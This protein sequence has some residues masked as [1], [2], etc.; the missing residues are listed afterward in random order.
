MNQCLTYISG[1]GCPTLGYIGP[2][3]GIAIAGSFLAILTATMST[4]SV[5]L[6]WPVKLMWKIATG[7]RPPKNAAYKRVI[8][9]GFD[10][11][12]PTTVEPMMQRG[13]LPTFSK[14]A[15]SGC[16]RRLGTTWPALSPVAW[17][18]FATGSN[19]GKH[20]IYDFVSR[21]QGTYRP[22]MSSVRIEPSHRALKLGKLRWPLGRSRVEQLRRSKPFWHA[23]GEAGYF[24]AILRVPITFPPDKFNGVQLS[25]MCVPDLRG[26]QG[27]YLRYTES[28]DSEPAD[29]SGDVIAVSRSANV[30]RSYLP[31]IQDPYR[32][33]GRTT[34][35]PFE[36]K[37]TKTNELLL[38]ID[39]QKVPLQL[40]TY[41]PWVRIRFR[42]TNGQ[43]VTGICRFRITRF[44]PPFQ[45]YVT[46]IQIDPAAPVMQIS[47]P[48]VF[49]K[50]LFKRQG[51]FA[52]LGLAEDTSALSDGAIDED[53]FLEQAYAIHQER[54][55]MLFDSMERVNQGA[56]TCV[57][58]APDRVQH[59]FYR[60]EDQ[61]H[62]ANADNDQTHR[63]VIRDM[64]I[65][66]DQTLKEI[67]DR[68]DERTAVIVMSDHGFASFRR[69]VDLN[70]WLRDHGYLKLRDDKQHSDEPDLKDVDWSQTTAYAFGL[71]GI[72][73]NL[74]GREPHGIVDRGE[75]QD[76]LLH[77]LK[78]K[79]S[80]L[81][82]TDTG[83]M[84][85]YEAKI[86]DEIYDGPYADGS[87]D[88]VP[89]YA[90]GYRVSWETARGQC[91]K[92]IFSDNTRAW[93]GD[94]CIHPDHVPG[95]L[96]ANVKLERD[97]PHIT[98]LAP[99]IL[100]LLGVSTPNYMDGTP[101]TC[102]DAPLTN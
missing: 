5:I 75:E 82:D 4:M 21:Q 70:A 77:E 8:V 9:I 24:S 43:S 14:L 40:N 72:Y 74:K 35:T 65:R 61:Q 20:N 64:T 98:D 99:T 50:Y 56:I 85:I 17:S 80:Q 69:A 33:D 48:Q 16:Y 93:S 23:L 91:A 28:T 102:A 52:T 100:N 7:K 87:P 62:P 31:G 51:A 49:S 1:L 57:F 83:D 89:G 95:I 68:I 94:H 84:A 92:N 19:P 37:Q 58:D 36:I 81:R 96:L 101:L 42:M 2:G 34:R 26:T 59:M 12:E 10:G 32:V 3:A 67:I 15:E 88:L 53:A 90:R 6:F 71:A 55:Q 11:L 22:G 60:F 45:M 73:V 78:Q 18:S 44:E 79:I 97:K 13:E 30:V 27:A 86:R 46:P 39:G 38:Q 29:A 54:K 25:A 63:H 47:H 66:M 76:R 41:S